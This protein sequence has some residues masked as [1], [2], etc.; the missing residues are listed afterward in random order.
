MTIS[1]RQRSN[2][3]LAATE[4]SYRSF[5]CKGRTMEYKLIRSWH[6]SYEF[7]ADQQH[8]PFTDVRSIFTSRSPRCLGSLPADRAAGSSPDS[9]SRLGGLNPQPS[10][11]S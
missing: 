9:G 11:P 7:T 2:G 4:A 5:P 3:S 8:Q 1:F 10:R 6:R